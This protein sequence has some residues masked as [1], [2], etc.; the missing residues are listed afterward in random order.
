[1]ERRTLDGRV[2]RRAYSLNTK[3]PSISQLGSDHEE[4]SQIGPISPDL[5]LLWGGFFAL[6]I[7]RE[8]DIATIVER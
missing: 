3:Q 6:S 7:F 8:V 2:K 5:P 4:K 1:M